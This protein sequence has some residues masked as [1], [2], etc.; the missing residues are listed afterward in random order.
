ML[1]LVKDHD[2][3]TFIGLRKRQLNLKR[4]YKAPFGILGAWF[5]IVVY[6][7]MLIFADRIALITAGIIGV[8]SV[9]YAVTIGAK[10]RDE[11]LSIEEEVR[12]IEEPTTR[13]K[14]KLDRQYMLWKYITILVTI[15]ALGIYVFP[16]IINL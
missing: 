9:I 5:T 11:A 16:I 6:G 2:R 3:L 1:H 12:V 15:V 7:F 4:P 8:L 13:E 14:A 10:Y